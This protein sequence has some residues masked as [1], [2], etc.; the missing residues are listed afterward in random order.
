MRIITDTHGELNNPPLVYT[1]LM[2][3]FPTQT[4]LEERIPEVQDALKQVYPIYE[5]RVQ[6]G[7]EIIRSDDNQTVRTIDTPE[8]MFFDSARTKGVILKSDRIIFH[9]SVYPNFEEF[10]AWF[11]DVAGA[12]ISILS[13]SHYLSCGIRYIDAVV[14][15]IASGESLEDYLQSSLLN[16]DICD[17]GIKKC[18]SSSQANVYESDIGV[19][20]FNSYISFNEGVCVPPDLKDI[21]GLLRFEIVKSVAPFAILD[22]DH[23]YGAPDGTADELDLD[24]LVV[25]ID[26]MHTVASNAFLS[27]ITENALGRWK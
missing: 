18:L 12:V 20:R 5:K 11:K 23:G 26:E 8:F 9:S 13:I 25:Q 19:V 14:P 15:D 4:S 21:A 24:K 22:F 10:S 17:N 2:V 16:F 27:A 3:R 1:V 7:I 6:Q